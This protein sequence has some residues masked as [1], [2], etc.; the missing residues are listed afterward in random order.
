MTNFV[1]NKPFISFNKAFLIVVVV[2]FFL[3]IYL[4][5]LIPKLSFIWGL[6]GAS[7]IFGLKLLID[8]GYANFIYQKK[9]KVKDSRF[10]EI[11]IVQYVL[12][13]HKTISFYKNKT[14]SIVGITYFTGEEQKFFLNGKEIYPDNSFE[15][16]EILSDLFNN[17]KKIEDF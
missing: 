3:L 4:S 2:A 7:I 17:I 5:L 13:D 14:N 8:W 6:L 9:N 10:P 12:L 1:I 11:D 15:Y 16:K